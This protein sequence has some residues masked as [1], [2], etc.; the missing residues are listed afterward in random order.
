MTFLFKYGIDHIL[1]DKIERNFMKAF[2]NKYAS[3]VKGSLS[4]FDRL[5]FRGTL[6]AL[7][8]ES[9]MHSYLNYTGILLKNFKE[10]ALEVTDKIKKASLQ[11]IEKAGRPIIYLSSS[12]PRKE[13]IAKEIMEK[14]R[15]THGSICTLTCVEPCY[16]YCIYRNRETQKLELRSRYTKCLHLYHYFIH[17]QLGFMSARLQTWFPFNIQI[18][19]NGREWLAQQMDKEGLAYER[20]ENC[21]VDL[22]DF[23]YAQ[24]L[25]NLQVNSAWPSLLNSIAQQ[26]NP[27]HDQLFESCQYYWTVFQ[28]EWATDIMFKDAASLAKIYPSLVHHGITNFSSPDAMRFLGHKIPSHGNVHRKFKGEVTSSLKDRPE[29]IRIKHYVNGNSIKLYDKQGSVLRTECTINNPSEFKVFRTKEGD[30]HCVKSWQSM[31][32]GIADIKRRSHVSQAAVNRYLDALSDFDT[33]TPLSKFVNSICHPAD[34]NGKRVRALNPWA[35][36]DSSLLKAVNCG[37]FA[38][39]GF[40]NKDLRSLIYETNATSKE[41]QK[42]RSSSVTRMLRLL[43][44]HGLIKKVNK[45]HRYL[46]TTKGRSIIN[47]LF[48]AYGASVDKLLDKAA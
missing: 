22:E 10:Y 2:I 38:I 6:R 29:G 31:R 43:R 27:I 46:L 30:E 12:K 28:S 14:G 47:S 33:S 9:G 18:C 44:A 39:N 34:L 13:R 21:F 1:I 36:N 37:E 41:D 20:R 8:F 23:E 48:A 24:E 15:I 32:K 3:V 42:K 11:V 7:A 17:P 26:V 5:V 25:M 40:R 19:I 35:D 16:S 45:T 4:G